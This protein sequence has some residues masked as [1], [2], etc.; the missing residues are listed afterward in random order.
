MITNHLTNTYLHYH[1][2]FHHLQKTHAFLFQFILLLSILMA[3][4][5]PCSAEIITDGSMGQ[6]TSL[7]GPDVIIPESLGTRSGT[8]LFHSFSTFSIHE[9]ENATFTGS[10]SL[11]NVISR[12]TGGDPSTIDGLLRSTIGS[13]DVFFINPSGIIF[14]P[15]A[16]V[17]VPAAFHVS[18]AEEIHFA[19]ETVLNCTTP[20]TSTLTQADPKAFGFLG[21][22]RS[23]IDIN[24]ST[25]EFT[26]ESHISLSAGDIALSP[27]D[28][29]SE[30]KI[31]CEN[32][33]I[34]L[35][36]VGDAS[37]SAITVN[38]GSDGT[39]K[40][41][42]PIPTDGTMQ[43]QEGRIDTS[44]DK[45]GNIVIQAGDLFSDG[46]KIVA[47]NLGD[48][49]GDSGIVLSING[50]IDM[51]NSSY[52]SKN[53]WGD[54]HAGTVAI[55]AA[56]LC[57]D[58]EG[59]TTGIFSQANEEKSNGT[60]GDVSIALSDDLLLIEGGHIS[61]D[62]YTQGDAGTIHITAHDI[63]VDGKE[64]YT[65]ISSDSAI[66][67]SPA[68]SGSVSLHL[69]GDLVIHD[70]GEISC[71]SYSDGN[72]GDVNIEA[73]NITIDGYG[74]DNPTGIFSQSSDL[75]SPGKSG[76]IDITVADTLLMRQRGFISGDSYAA[77]N[78]GDIHIT[79]DRLVM[80]GEGFYTAISSD[81]MGYDSDSCAG[82]VTIDADTIEMKNRAEISSQSRWNGDAG[83][84]LIHA[85]NLTINGEG[86][87]SGIYCQTLDEFSVADAGTIEIDVPGTITL[88]DG[89]QI[90]TDHQA[91]AGDK[92]QIVIS[93]GDIFIDGH[94]NAGYL[95][96]EDEFDDIPDDAVTDFDEMIHST[97][98]WSDVV[99][100]S[101]SQAGFI[102]ITVSG[103]L[104]LVNGGLI[105]SST[106]SQGDAGDITITADQIFMDGNGTDTGIFSDRSLEGKGN[107][108]TIRITTSGHI[109]LFEDA[110][111]SSDTLSQGQGG[112]IFI[113][114]ES[115]TIDGE[116]ALAG[117]LSST[118][119]HTDGDTC[120]DAGTIDIV[121]AN[122]IRLIKGGRISSS[123][124]STGNAG[125]ITIS[126]ERL[127][128][129]HQ[130]AS[131]TTKIGSIS[132][133][134]AGNAGRIKITVEKDLQLL[135]SAEISTISDSD[136][137]GNSGDISITAS[138]LLLDFGR[139]TNRAYS[140][141]AGYL[142]NIGITAD[143]VKLS[144]NSRISTMAN[145]TLSPDQLDTLSDSNISIQAHRVTLDNQSLITSESGGNVPASDIEINADMIKIAGES[146][147]TTAADHAD[148]GHIALQG[149]NFILTEGQITTS[150]EESNGDGGN[151]T[152]QGN[153]EKEIAD[154]LVM[155]R[156]F[157]QANTVAD[158]A[159]GGDI[160]LD[161]KG[162][163]FDRSGDG[164]TIDAVERLDFDENPH[165]SVIQ[166]AAPNGTQGEIVYDDTS[167]LDISGAVV[168]IT[169]RKQN[170]MP[171]Y[172]DPCLISETSKGSAL[173]HHHTRNKMY[174]SNRP[175]TLRFNETRLNRFFDHAPQTR[176]NDCQ[177][178]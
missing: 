7:T 149:K 105:S 9:G 3:L 115:L 125:N 94:G 140:S 4:T 48:D 127:I 46:G 122:S 119:G 68:K 6:A 154:H 173:F 87:I 1:K 129:D 83:H 107:A 59:N 34:H 58:G 61:T 56:S 8:N 97:G 100:T 141:N 145:Q 98:I 101:Q 28:N 55:Q 5:Y 109:Q 143:E 62:S 136:I 110:Y 123:T 33:D 84:V 177:S 158:D 166:A 37:I 159:E 174:R 90:V 32:G 29:T 79:T 172:D 155:K 146:R 53:S 170:I 74:K 104:M 64:S 44:G 27:S 41:D 40:Y 144:N 164:L 14:G 50:S 112:D 108:G 171:I 114:A 57:I 176:V 43:I 24:G 76:N 116:W 70:G 66:A 153:Y 118:Y 139:V 78:G 47:N 135:S 18:T 162:I 17:D 106:F 163:L 113:A 169:P 126:C 72:A 42:L 160:L 82:S 151:I 39:G 49:D 96:A 51:Q 52:I 21:A 124:S 150:V 67:D 130:D 175:S 147:V 85:E 99:G 93:A 19:D 10:D 11:K 31:T 165:Q 142:G 30:A 152:I 138:A 121:V 38:M 12:V 54:G 157:I 20:E 111:I 26:P 25:L 95:F 92:G 133:E 16:A 75:S 71:N 178:L 148:G 117:I 91:E 81:I 102:D 2:R 15:H 132:Q 35:T 77:G 80:D 88:I 13:A 22:Q 60:S 134:E 63:T 86:D 103:T 45:G 73:K 156:G 120:G 23:R 167:L 128:L 65:A 131:Y 69:K 161:V 36:T 137:R 89:A 168:D